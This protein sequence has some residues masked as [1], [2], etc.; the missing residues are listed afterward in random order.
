MSRSEPL[1]DKSLFLKYEFQWYRLHPGV[2]EGRRPMRFAY[3]FA[4]VTSTVFA[5]QA[6][7]GFIAAPSFAIDP[8]AFAVAVGD[9]NGDGNLDLAIVNGGTDG[10]M[11]AYQ[12]S[13]TI[14][15]GKRDGTFQ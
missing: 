15:L 11:P 8:S 7:A 4:I 3:V 1:T 5:W 9:F 10:T 12:G 13:V 2:P 14:A 6:S